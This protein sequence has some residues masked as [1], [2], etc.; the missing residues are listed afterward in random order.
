MCITTHRFSHA[1]SHSLRNRRR[2][3]HQLRGFPT[4]GKPLLSKT[5][6]VHNMLV[7]I[8]NDNIIIYYCTYLMRLFD[9]ILFNHT[10][11]SYVNLVFRSMKSQIF[12]NVRIFSMDP[13]MFTLYIF[14]LHCIFLIM[15]CIALE[16]Y[17]TVCFDYQP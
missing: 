8:V 13:H 12:Y 9:D 1:P 10:H 4:Y 17:I 16:C 2:G 15:T 11:Y 6:P 5:T 3:H 7:A 14:V